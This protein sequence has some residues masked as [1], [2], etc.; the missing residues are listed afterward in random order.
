M[1]ICSGKKADYVTLSR[2]SLA[3]KGLFLGLY[4]ILRP[5]KERQASE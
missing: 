1:D 4:E 3:A 5:G 2:R